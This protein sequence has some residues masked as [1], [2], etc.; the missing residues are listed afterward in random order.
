[1]GF[2]MSARIHVP[3]RIFDKWCMLAVGII[4]RFSISRDSIDHKTNKVQHKL[5]PD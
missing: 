2:V 1:M 5:E 4:K 3:L